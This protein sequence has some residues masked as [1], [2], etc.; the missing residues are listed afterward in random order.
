MMQVATVLPTP[1]SV[2]V[3]NRPGVLR[4][5]SF[6]R[7]DSIRGRVVGGVVGCYE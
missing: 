4:E 7:V 1:V 6:I 2:A 5:G 3:M